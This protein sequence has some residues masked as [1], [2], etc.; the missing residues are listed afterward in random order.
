MRFPSLGRLA[1]WQGRLSR[2]EAIGG[3]V[4]LVG[5][6]FVVFAGLMLATA[7]GALAEQMARR[8]ALGCLAAFLLPASALLAQRA[9]DVGV[10]GLTLL[11]VGLLLNAPG[12][13]LALTP[14]GLTASPLLAA[15]LGGGALWGLVCAA[16]LAIPS[17]PP[18]ATDEVHV[19]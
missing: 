10:S 5:V 1:S 11:A 17:R 3:L 15:A 13:A 18:A 7:T 9:R 19:G 2:S 14:L 12:L 8:V 4:F 16:L 6:F